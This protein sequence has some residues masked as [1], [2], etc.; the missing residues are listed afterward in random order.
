LAEKYPIDSFFYFLVL[1]GLLE[2]LT[3]DRILDRCHGNH[4]H[5][6]TLGFKLRSNPHEKTVS[7]DEVS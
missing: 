2:Q 7:E 1:R 5:L 6:G 4:G 3:N